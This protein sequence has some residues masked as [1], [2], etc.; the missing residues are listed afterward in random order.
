MRAIRLRK[1]GGLDQLEVG[2][3][4]A[5]TPGRGEIRVRLHASSLNYHDLIVVLGGIPTPDGRIPMSD[6]AGE[7]VAVGEG[8]TEFA[9][10]DRVVSTFFPD[11]IG[12]EPELAMMGAVP[13]DRTDGYA[14]EEVVA[15]ATAFTR[16]PKGYSHAEAATL[17]CA[18]LT[19][20]RALFVEEKVLPGQTVLVQGTGGVSIF[21][22][23]FAKAAGATVIATSSG[24]EKLQRLRDLGADHVIN[25]REDPNWGQ[26]ARALTGGRGVD[27]VV[28]V[29][30]PGT[31]AQSIMASKL[32]GHVSLIGVLT[33]IAGDVP[34][35][36]AMAGNVRISGI[37]VGS[38]EQ[39]QSQR[40]F[41]KI[42]I[43]W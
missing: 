7:V 1:P 19:A 32:R 21:A 18:A 42:V 16:A 43:E 8:V 29:G 33:G 3:A 20:W 34:T 25:Y 2:T 28:E 14:R 23:Q 9:V 37:T 36:M 17:T 12:G 22:L 26:T 15:P 39:Q 4:D 5:G 31:L 38:R 27:H 30:G 6:G 24:P 11:W 41:G 10:G 40:H 13:G 35:A